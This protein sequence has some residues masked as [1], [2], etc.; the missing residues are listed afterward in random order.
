MRYLIPALQD[1]GAMLKGRRVAPVELYDR[2]RKA[3][4]FGGYQGVSMIA[5][6][7]LDMAA[8]DALAKASGVPLCVLLG[9]SVG[10]VKAYN[11]NGLWLQAPEVV[12]ADAIALRDEGGFT[13]LKLRLGRDRAGDDLAAAHR[14]MAS[15]GGDMEPMAALNQ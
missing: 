9:G 12:A 5:V 8:W 15:L 6:S 4:S 14:L 10:P 1:F 7:G 11:S 3:L 13:A 2:G